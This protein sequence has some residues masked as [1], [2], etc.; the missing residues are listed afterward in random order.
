VPESGKSVSH[1]KSASDEAARDVER[2]RFDARLAELR[3]TFLA[4]QSESDRNAAGLSMGR[5]LSELFAMQ[6]LE[7]NEPFRAVEERIDGAFLFDSEVYLLEAKWT[8]N[9][10]GES[11]LLSFQEKIQRKSSFACALL[12]SIN[13]FSQPA[14]Q[15]ATTAR[16]PTLVM[17]DGADLYRVLEGHIRLDLLLRRKVRRLA[18]RGEPFVPVSD[19]LRSG[20]VDDL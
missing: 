7:P 2:R 10:V 12:I 6:D 11:E 1:G 9:V 8:A 13:G 18:E 19:L 20:W 3:A 5:V 14:M 17:M 15:A 16:Q 4:I